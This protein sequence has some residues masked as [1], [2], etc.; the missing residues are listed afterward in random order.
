MFHTLGMLYVYKP[1]TWYQ[2]C[3]SDTELMSE[4]P[5][6][7]LHLYWQLPEKTFEKQTIWLNVEWWLVAESVDSQT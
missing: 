3:H 7:V 6:P 5:C 1:N 4:S 2:K